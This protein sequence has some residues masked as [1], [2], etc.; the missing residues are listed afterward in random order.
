MIVDAHVHIWRATANYS[1]PAVT[2][3]SP[4]SDVSL[5]LL[6]DYLE[7]HGVERAVLVQPLYPAQDN[8][9]VADCAAAQPEKYAAV[10]VVDPSQA[11][12][13]ER[14]DYWVTERGCKGLR[15]RPMIASEE[16]AFLAPQSTALWQRAAALGTVINIVA[17]PQ[18]LLTIRER[19]E[20]FPNVPIILDHMAHPHPTEGVHAPAFQALLDLARFPNIYIKPT[21]YYYF[22]G[23]RYPYRDCWE[24]FR[25]VF[26][27]FGAERLIWGS[28]FP[29]VLLKTG[30]RRS[31]LMQERVFS[32]LTPADLALIMGENALRLYWGSPT[33]Q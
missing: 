15:L 26:D 4:F 12:A 23:Q 25:A 30:Y 19:A 21:G 27:H 29:H 13:A 7:E 20:Q 24:L 10:C 16:G 17:R 14:L 11:D 31:L 1:N 2:I 9:Y 28:D 33:H 18:H 22:S 5:E 6:A 8:S 32:F 3:V